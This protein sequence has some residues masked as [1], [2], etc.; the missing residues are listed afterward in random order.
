MAVEK[1]Q[2][3]WARAVEH[4]PGG[5]NSPVRAFRG[6]GG[7]PFFVVSGQGPYLRTEDGQEYI[8]YV[9]GYG[10]LI[11]GH[12]H[13]G[14][15]E[16]VYRQAQ[17]GLSFGTPTRLEV[18]MAERLS[19]AVSS[20]PMLRM[21]NSGTEATMTALRVARG[22]TGR[23]YVVKF[24]GSYHGH[25]DSLL[26]KAGSG[27]ATLGVPDS[28]GV[29]ADIAALTLT[30]PYNDVDALTRLFRDYGSD[31]AAVIA[32][33][34]AGNMGTVLP[35]AGFLEAIRTLTVR[36]GALWV[37]DE[38]MTGFRVNWGSVAEARGLMPDLITLAKVIGAGMPMGAY[39]GAREYLSLVSPLGPVYQAGT[40][41]GNAVALAAGMAQLTEVARPGFYETLSAHTAALA[42]GLLER[43]QKHHVDVAVNRAGGM[44]TLFFRSKPPRNFDEVLQSDADRYSRW[45]HGMLDRGV[46]LPP[47]PFETVFLS[48]AHTDVEISRTLE[49]ADQ[50]FKTL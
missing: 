4:L 37:S 45:F 42:D 36:Y 23:R 30:S 2:Q 14:V 32:E 41:S 49:A 27:A 15:L 50:V 22:V 46:F 34:V 29:P 44:F 39:G 38:V 40:F 19:Q 10:P 35:E 11:L 24:A 12:A 20:A 1:S 7:E 5:V 26:I 33:P 3:L 13:P 8:D 6:V 48:S 17:R 18:E 21:V 28:A 31:I 9:L 16:A 25:H 47:S 43:A